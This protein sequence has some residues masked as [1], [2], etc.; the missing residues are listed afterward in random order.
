V[1]E[2]RVDARDDLVRALDAESSATDLELILAAWRRWGESCVEHFIGDFS[3]AISDGARLFCARD[4]FGVRPL[5]YARHDGALIVTNTLPALLDIVP[6]DL[7]RD[8]VEELIVHGLTVSV[9]RT[10][11]ARIA[12][13][14]P[15]HRLI[16]EGDRVRVER[17]WSFPIRDAPLDIGERDAV[18]QFRDHLTNA[19]KDRAR[20]RVV[21]S[22]SGGIDSTSIAA[23]LA[24][25]GASVR[26]LTAVWDELIPDEERRFSEA[27]ARALGIPIEFQVCDRYQPFE[28]WWEPRVRGAEPVHEPFSAAFQDYMTMAAGRGSV[29]MGGWGGDPML[30]TSQSYF[31]DLLRRGRWPWFAWEALRYAVTRRRLPPLLLRSRLLRAAGLHKNRDTPPAWLLPPLRER[32][33]APPPVTDAR[34]HPFR[35]QA[36]RAVMSAAWPAVFQSYH[37]G[38]TGQPVE[39][40]AP[41]FDTRLLEF[42][43]SLPPMPHFAGKDVLRQAMRGWLPN[44]VRLRPKTPLRGD[45]LAVLWPRVQQEWIATVERSGALDAWIDRRILLDELRAGMTPNV[46]QHAHAIALARWLEYEHEP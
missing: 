46:R 4:R 38:A 14:P 9:A 31:Y 21:V 17:Y 35:P 23:T 3:F 40:A 45:P 12:R 41:F 30:A 11:F 43:F 13:V 22:M 25:S 19:V 26:A 2:A 37:S 36:F 33:N 29:L 7:D 6:H 28:R 5:Y 44:E 15:A 18:E 42:A 32:W 10:T 16:A 20:G 24:R 1:G 34:V 27:A 8:A 39:C